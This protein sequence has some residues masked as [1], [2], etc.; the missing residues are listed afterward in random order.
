ML[1]FSAGTRNAYN[2]KQTNKNQYELRNT[3][4]NIIKKKNFNYFL[5]IFKNENKSFC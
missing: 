1:K 2:N 3:M 4:E 5:D